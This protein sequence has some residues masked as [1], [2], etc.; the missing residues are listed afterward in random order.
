MTALPACAAIRPATDAEIDAVTAT[1]AHRVLHSRASSATEPP[2]CAE[3][4]RNRA[5]G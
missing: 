4:C 5:D 1:H 2:A 3:I